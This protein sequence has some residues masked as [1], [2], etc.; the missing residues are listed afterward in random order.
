VVDGS[1]SELI[2]DH[3]DTKND[4][5]DGDTLSPSIQ[6]ATAVTI[7]LSDCPKTRNTRSDSIDYIGSPVYTGK[8]LLDNPEFNASSMSLLTKHGETSYFVQHADK[9]QINIKSE[10]PYATIEYPSNPTPA[11]PD[12]PLP[13]EYFT[14]R[15][16]LRHEPV[17]AEFITGGAW[18]LLITIATGIMQLSVFVQLLLLYR[19]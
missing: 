11:K 1:A 18:V 2:V 9:K 3:E 16:Q 5:N 12:R 4:I 15:K 13:E 8:F 14:W 19:R 7:P 6:P 10:Q 17:A